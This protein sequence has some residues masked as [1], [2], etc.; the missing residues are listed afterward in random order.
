MILPEK[1][2]FLVFFKKHKLAQ[3]MFI[4]IRDNEDK[5]SMTKV[6]D[7]IRKYVDLQYIVSS[8]KNGRHFHMLVKLK[9]EKNFKPR[10]SKK[11][12]FHFL[13]LHK[14][15][16]PRSLFQ[17]DDSA[18]TQKRYDEFCD[19]ENVK[20]NNTLFHLTGKYN[21]LITFCKVHLEKVSKKQKNKKIRIEKKNKEEKKI[22]SFLNYLEK[23]LNEN[24]IEDIDFYTTFF[25]KKNT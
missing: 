16:P 14:P 22:L 6:R 2:E 18:K 9:D 11:I 8:P 17:L 15:I 13:P 3:L 10:G 24:R 7:W 5:W 19:A 20:R 1:A 4:T 21:C 23:N 12:H 25:H